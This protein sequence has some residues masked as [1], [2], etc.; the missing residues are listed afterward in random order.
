M[1]RD[2]LRQFYTMAIIY[3]AWRYR[4]QKDNAVL[5]VRNKPFRI[6]DGLN[7]YM[8]YKDI[9]IR[10]IYEFETSNPH[11][12][13]I[14]GGSNIGT[15]I[16]FFKLKYPNSKIIG[17]EPDPGVFRILSENIQELHDQQI[18]L[19]NA[20][21]GKESGT[22][23]FE[24]DGNVGGFVS[25]TQVGNIPIELVKLSSYIRSETDYVKLNIEGLE[26][27]V[28]AEVEKAGLLGNIKQLAV[29]YHGWND[30]YQSL[31]KILEILERNHFRYMIHDF[32][33]ETCSSTKPPIRFSQKSN[34][35][36][37]VYATNIAFQQP[38]KGRN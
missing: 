37:M 1:I 25:G 27:E 34:W 30:G 35:F 16:L 32:D 31:G 8:Q 10:R 29:E 28:L 9:F 22:A 11:P 36:C 6:I 5:K 12:V 23:F 26:Y 38:L 7:F 4:W 17:F 21:L 14:D 20:G 13:I 18:T 33:F 2:V 3:W 19:I 24:P 15:S